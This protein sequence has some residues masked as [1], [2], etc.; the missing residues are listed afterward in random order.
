[1]LSSSATLRQSQ[2]YPGL[3][4]PHRYLTCILS[5]KYCHRMCI[6]QEVGRQKPLNLSFIH[7]DSTFQWFY[8]LNL[9]HTPAITEILRTLKS[10]QVSHTYAVTQALPS[11]V[12][13]RSN[14]HPK[15]AQ[16]DVYTHGL[17]NSLV[18]CSQLPPKP[19]VDRDMPEWSPHRYPTH[20]VSHNL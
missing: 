4:S 10:T 2:R 9:R 8:A 14:G 13:V 19:G 17:H 11:H 16:I 18:V 1:M 5:H 20:F 6:C 3:S 7:T 12:Y 15:I